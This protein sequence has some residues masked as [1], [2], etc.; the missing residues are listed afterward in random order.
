LFLM[1][2]LLMAFFA[3]SLLLGGSLLQLFWVYY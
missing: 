2:F 1:L 3:M